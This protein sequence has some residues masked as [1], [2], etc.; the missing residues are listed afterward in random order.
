MSDSLQPHGVSLQAPLSLGFSRQKYLSVL[1]F[2]PQYYYM[3]QQFHFVPKITESRNTTDM[4]PFMSPQ[5]HYSPQQ[6]WVHLWVHSSIIHLSQKVEA[7][8]VPTKGW[9]NK[10]NG[11]L[12]DNGMLS[13]L[14]NKST[15]YSMNETWGHYTKQNKSI[16]KRQIQYH[17]AYVR[18]LKVVKLRD[19][20]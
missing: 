7:I 8:Q 20:K 16:A 13:C 9:L 11:V 5:Q 3:I 17:P 12:T 15:Y 6:I 19:R 18:S 1:P 2:P 4:S 14:K 10:Q